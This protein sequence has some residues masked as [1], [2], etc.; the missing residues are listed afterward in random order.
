MD[1][2][3]KPCVDITRIPNILDMYIIGCRFCTTIP[4]VYDMHLGIGNFVTE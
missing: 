2:A 4:K 3:E 1:V